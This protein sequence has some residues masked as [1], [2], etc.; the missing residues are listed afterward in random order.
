MS[1]S[2]EHRD[3]LLNEVGEAGPA[4]AL[5]LGARSLSAEEVRT[6][7]FRFKG[8]RG[9]GLLLPFGGDFAQCR[10]DD[11][12]MGPD[13]KPV[14]YLNRPK[15]KQQPVTVGDGE[16]TLATEGFKDAI[17]LH[18]L[19][20]ETVQGLPGVSCT[21]LLAP[22]VKQIVYDADASLNPA[23]WGALIRAGLERGCRLSFFPSD[24][25]G[26]KG[27]ASEFR[28]AGGD[29]G[30][31]RWRSARE[32]LREIS[33]LWSRNLRTD[34]KPQALRSI[35][36]LAN[37][38]GLGDMT[39]ELLTTEAA[40]RIG[41]RV[42]PA[43]TIAAKAAAPKDGTAASCPSEPT[44]QQLQSFI[45]GTYAV[46]LNELSGRVELNGAPMDAFDF[47]DT[48][49]AH[50]HGLETTKQAAKDTF[51]YVAAA[52]P[53]NPIA[54]YFKG[55]RQRDDLKLLS[56][57]AIAGAFGVL[58][59]DTLSQELMARHLAGAYLRG[60]EPGYKHDQML[61]LLGDQG[62][63]KGE[64]IRALAGAGWYDSATRIPKHLEDREFLQK[65]NSA[66]LFE[67]DE[68]EK[69]LL[70]R[71]AAEMK[72]FT[73]RTVD[74]YVQKWATT[75]GEHPRR[76]VLFGSSNEV[77]VLNDTTGSRRFWVV[78]VR[79][80]TMRP[81]WIRHHRDSIWATV[82][83]WV[84]WGLRN[85]V[86]P[87]HPTAVAAAG[88]AAEARLSHVW[89][90]PIRKVLEQL[91]PDGEG[92]GQD[93]LIE[94][95]LGQDIGKVD[96]RVQMQVTRIVRASDFTTHGETVRWERKRLRYGGGH[97]RWGYVPALVPTAPTCSNQFQGDWNGQMPWHDRRL[98]APFQ[99]FQ[100][101]FEGEQEKEIRALQGAERA[102]AYVSH[103]RGSDPENGWN[104]WNTPKIP[105]TGTDLTV[106]PPL[107]RSD[108]S[109][110]PPPTSERRRK[111]NH[112]DR[113]AA[114]PINSPVEIRRD[115]KPP[116][117]GHRMLD[118]LGRSENCHLTDPSGG[119]VLKPKSWIWPC[120]G[121]S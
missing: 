60:I 107:G 32:L 47:A 77:E 109:D 23:V 40:K 31:L 69:T 66:W 72:G 108:R 102:D 9:S 105:C 33:S 6:I 46:R 93:T 96:R 100:P 36:R 43:R 44:K 61:L 5:E 84:D 45:R 101:F 20:G 39:A 67:F 59:G 114:I 73:S 16:P 86:P 24:V 29:F 91:L 38:A 88:R 80:G 48:F 121:G 18:L 12:P 97:S 118:H 52:N 81:D 78:D 64:C 30:A 41:V 103:M 49:L 110:Q 58:P 63:G 70:G 111:P 3:H 22:T 65:L 14:R 119:T 120:G 68:A 82:A 15:A 71:D 19:T 34:W 83:T 27:G 115:G 25:A 74:R 8:W 10:L 51:A 4:I 89:E 99:L 106:Q 1:L 79:G 76:C 104:G 87:N 21:R 13:G 35:A 75:C 2:P 54:A 42:G 28:L 94:Q 50:E 113:V 37:E 85:W 26:H 7:G 90:G 112:R 57:E 95:A 55:L 116:V 17:S 62:Q 92:I 117:N 53:F 56:I 11:P 98:T